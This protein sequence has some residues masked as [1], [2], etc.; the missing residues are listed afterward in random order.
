MKFTR[1]TGPSIGLTDRDIQI[2]R[3]ILSDGAKTPSD[4]TDRFWDDRSRKAKAG[5]QRI[6][7]LVKAGLLEHGNPRLLYLTD[8]AKELLSKASVEGVKADALSFQ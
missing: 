3:W 4:L 2:L 1:A 7:K 8:H 5:F 6:R